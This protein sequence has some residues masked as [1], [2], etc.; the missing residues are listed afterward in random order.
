MRFVMRLFSFVVLLVFTV[1]LNAAP[2]PTLPNG[3]LKIDSKRIPPALQGLVQTVAA[4]VGKL[5]IRARVDFE[6]KET[7]IKKGMVFATGTA[8]VIEPGDRINT[9]YHVISDW[10]QNRNHLDLVFVF[11]GKEI[12]IDKVLFEDEKADL[13]T[14]ALPEKTK[15]A[16]PVAKV[17]LDTGLR[18][19]QL[20]HPLSSKTPMVT[21]GNV[22]QN[23]EEGL[24][25]STP[26]LPGLSG[27]PI[28]AFDEYGKMLGVIGN[29]KG[30]LAVSAIKLKGL[31]GALA[32]DYYGLDNINERLYWLTSRADVEKTFRIEKGPQG[33]FKSD[34]LE[35]L[36]VPRGQL[37]QAT[38]MN[39][40]LLRNDHN[41]TIFRKELE[42]ISKD[43][44]SL[45]E[46]LVNQGKEKPPREVLKKMVTLNF[47]LEAISAR[48]VKNLYPIS[49][50]PI[51]TSEELARSYV[52]N[53]TSAKLARFLKGVAIEIRDLLPQLDAQVKEDNQRKALVTSASELSK[54]LLELEAIPKLKEDE[55]YFSHFFQIPTRVNVIR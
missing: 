43:F 30:I 52:S 16:L 40:S 12:E 35:E 9:D 27:A 7:K 55:V 22:I 46:Q 20:G 44:D 6:V 2:L 32:I 14:L 54:Y 34:P 53:P 8:Y 13:A 28:V 26:S 33:D 29:T 18:V 19:I 1:V 49:S 23:D 25:L 50:L 45:A 37:E 48:A 4:A 17:E 11:G 38:M 24:F 41:V 42:E 15:S 21:L 31:E 39:F 47:R 5:E 3:F 51:R 36:K 10:I